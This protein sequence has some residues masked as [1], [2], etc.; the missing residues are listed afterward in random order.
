[1][2]R[3]SHEQVRELYRAVADEAGMD[4]GTASRLK[5]QFAAQLREQIALGI[6]TYKD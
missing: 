5:S 1:M 6:P 3:P 2:Q 4:Q